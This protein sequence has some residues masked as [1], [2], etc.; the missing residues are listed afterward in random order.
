MPSSDQD[1]LRDHK[2]PTCR[3]PDNGRLFLLETVAGMRQGKPEGAFA[4][5]AWDRLMAPADAPPAQPTRAQFQRAIA[6]DLE[7]LLNTRAAVADEVL[8]GHPHCRKSIVNFGLADFA[9][10]CLTSSDDRKAI[11]E[12]LKAAIERHE[13]RLDKVRAHLLREPG[14]VNRLSFVI[15]GQLRASADDQRLRFD[16]MLERSS[17]HYSIR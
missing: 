13:P 9:Q 10:I 4:P 11:C 16:V 1:L 14:A 8:A 7:A 2:F 5:G 17:L 6:R 3:S 12:R 15:E